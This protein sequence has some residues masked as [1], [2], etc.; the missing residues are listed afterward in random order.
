VRST[1]LTRAPARDGNRAQ[2]RTNHEHEHEW[3]LRGC[4]FSGAD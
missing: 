1:T 3:K 2:R 4:K